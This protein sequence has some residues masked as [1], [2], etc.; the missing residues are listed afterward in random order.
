MSLDELHDKNSLISVTT[1]HKVCS[2]FVAHFV[3]VF[4]NFL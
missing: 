4:L 2:Q 3:V 1:L